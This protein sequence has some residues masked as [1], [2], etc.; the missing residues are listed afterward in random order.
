MNTVSKVQSFKQPHAIEEPT[1]QDHLM[2]E[3]SMGEK[4]WRLKFTSL[5]LA[6]IGIGI[7]LLIP[8]F[9]S[10]L[11][12]DLSIKRERLR[13]ATVQRGE[14]VSE[15]VAQGTVVAAISPTLFA[16]SSGIVTLE[17]DAGDKVQQGDVVAT[18]HNPSLE[19][20]LAREQATFDTLDT[21][22]KGRAIEQKQIALA[23]QQRVD[24]A[25]LALMAAER[26][27]KRADALSENSLI[28]G[29]DYERAQDVL[30]K[31]RIDYQ[32]AQ[33]TAALEKEAL[34]FD[35]LKAEQNKD[36]QGLVLKN[37]QRLA[38][39]LTLRSPVSGIVGTL[40][41]QQKATVTSN[42]PIVTVVDLSAFEIEAQIPESYA[43]SLGIGMTAIV[44]IGESNYSA[45]LVAVSPEITNNSVVARIR[46]E[47]ESPPNLRQNQRVTVQ[48]HLEAKDNVLVLER[49][50]FLD[51]GGG[52]I[53]YVINNQYAI[54]T[55]IQIGSSSI[56]HVEII[57]G[58]NEG[59]EVVISDL[60]VF[61]DRQQILITN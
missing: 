9:I 32:H 42:S 15:I 61:Q 28:S 37:L 54:K 49:G 41:V 1:G 16:S 4:L 51:S 2:A 55:P 13:I 14:F 57:S 18:I 22:L 48:I 59:D 20:E 24:L 60:S 46:F 17:V 47:G 19:N 44:K 56:R 25:K 36:R 58:L 52:R 43:G 40:A 27:L 29:Q 50:N 5:I 34:D 39:E 26:E 45:Q 53:A 7:I 38:D 11:D 10:I 33:Q 30:E 8:G 23:S 3:P 12:A 35:R 6:F 21:E 31:A